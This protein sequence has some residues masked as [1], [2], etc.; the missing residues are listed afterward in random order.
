MAGHAGGGTIILIAAEKLPNVRGYIAFSPAASIWSSTP[1]V[2]TLLERWTQNAKA[3]VFV[4]QPENDFNIEPAR[5]LG[6]VLTK[7]GGANRTKVY[8]PYRNSEA[9]ANTFGYSAPDIWGNDV[10]SFLTEVLK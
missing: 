6:A 3:P 9:E 8:P 1:A 4:I 2:Q 5:V 7:K 10:L